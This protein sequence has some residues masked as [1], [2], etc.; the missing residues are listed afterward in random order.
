[1]VRHFLRQRGAGQ[2][3]VQFD[4]DL[5]EHILLAS[6]EGN[7]RELSAAVARLSVS[8]KN[9]IDNP[10][11]LLRQALGRAPTTELPCARPIAAPPETVEELSAIQALFEG[12]I[13]GV[14]RYYGKERQQVYRWLE[15]FGLVES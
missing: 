13:S 5:L 11:I 7:V 15:K 1:M 12:N 4:S 2:A 10:Q 8:F 9:G 3:S 6:W 14:S